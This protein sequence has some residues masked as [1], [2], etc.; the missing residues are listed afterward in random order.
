M[1]KAVL[2]MTA[3]AAA[4]GLM[5]FAGAPADARPKYKMV[6]DKEYLTEGSAIHK[7]WEGKSNCNACHQGK[8]RKNRNAYGA[9]IGKA[10]GE[11]NVMDEAKIK[12]ALAAAAKEKAAGSDKSFGDLIKDGSWKSTPEE[13]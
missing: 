1:K 4:V 13:K 10:L 5:L 3:V 9:A 11:K 8:D 6:W 7:A 2:T 12:E